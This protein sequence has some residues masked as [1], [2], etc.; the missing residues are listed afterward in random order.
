MGIDLILKAHRIAF[1]GFFVLMLYS[2]FFYESGIDG[3]GLHIIS[4]IYAIFFV[5]IL[6]FIGFSF[7]FFSGS[8]VFPSGWVLILGSVFALV[9]SLLVSGVYDYNLAVNRLF[10]YFLGLIFYFSLLQVGFFKFENKFFLSAFLLLGFLVS[11]SGFFQFLFGDFGFLN[12]PLMQDG[13][14]VSFFHQVNVYS[15]ALSFFAIVFLCYLLGFFNIK[16]GRGLSLSFV[17]FFCLVMIFITGSRVGYISF[18]LAFFLLSVLFFVKGFFRKNFFKYISCIFLIVSSFFVGSSVSDGVQRFSDKSSM[19]YS[20]ESDSRYHIYYISFNLIKDRIL[21]GYGYGSFQRVFADSRMNYP[22]YNEETKKYNLDQS[23]FGHPHNEILY[24]GIEGGVFGIV[25]ILF[26][27]LFLAYQGVKGG[28]LNSIILF[29]ISSPFVLHMLVEFP[30]Y[31]SFWHWF[32]FLSVISCFADKRVVGYGFNGFSIIIYAI[33]SFFIFIFSFF[34]IHSFN[35]FKSLNGYF[36]SGGGDIFYLSR[37]IGNFYF[38]RAASYFLNRR[39]YYYAID[40]NDFVLLEGFAVWAESY[41]KV[42]PDMHIY[43]DLIRSYLVLGEY[44]R[45][46]ALSEEVLLI[47]PGVQFLKETDA[48]L[49]NIV[50]Q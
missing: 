16:V 35:S 30:F 24:W 2:I 43:N 10:V 6:I 31:I 9:L 25:S 38:E 39:N 42:V 15:S 40:N 26:V 36:R 33:F 20:L 27:F 34:S 44:D 8:F 11:L 19:V 4:N 12:M 7:S 48:Y 47:Y 50:R 14:P 37:P 45:A 22:Q 5:V 46:V 49:K 17:F 3:Y 1:F 28:F 13:R 29:S 18:G 41:L 23:R 32:V 21:T